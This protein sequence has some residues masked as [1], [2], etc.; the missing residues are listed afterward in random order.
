MG[1][2]HLMQAM[3]AEAEAQCA[4]VLDAA[5]AG[6]EALEAAARNAAEERRRTALDALSRQ[7]AVLEAQARDRAEAEAARN[8]FSVQDRLV[9]EAMDLA[10]GLLAEKARTDGFGDVLEKLATEALALAEPG[11]PVTVRVPARHAGRAAAAL[12]GANRADARVAS[13]DA[14]Q[15]GVVIEADDGSFRISNT[16]SMRL[17]QRAPEAHTLAHLRFFPKTGGRT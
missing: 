17:M 14:P 11:C 13:D 4:A 10:G 16:L 2:E 9:R 15:D 8:A 6:A 7:N 5:R 1:T 12:R 3:T